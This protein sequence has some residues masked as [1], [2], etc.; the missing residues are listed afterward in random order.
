MEFK[1]DESAK[2]ATS[3]ERQ[4]MNGQ[5]IVVRPRQPKAN[6]TPGGS[7]GSAKS[8]RCAQKDGHGKGKSSEEQSKQNKELYQALAKEESVSTLQNLSSANRLWNFVTY[9]IIV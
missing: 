4:V 1:N 7:V 2:S 5:K 3:V 9:F 6:P 8:R